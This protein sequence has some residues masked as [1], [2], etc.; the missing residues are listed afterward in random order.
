MDIFLTCKS[1]AEDLVIDFIEL[2]LKTGETVSLD[3]D[4][5]YVDRGQGGRFEAA[6]EGIN[7]CGKSARGKLS[8]LEGA[9]ITE[10]GLY[11]ESRGRADLDILEMSIREGSRK[12]I[13]HA[14]YSVRGAEACG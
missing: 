14:P 9:A 12:L 1:D 7:I 4:Q 10:V 11:S 5:S 6:Y 8:K 13:F 3:W 2:K